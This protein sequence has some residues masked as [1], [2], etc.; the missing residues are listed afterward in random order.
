[1]KAGK[2]KIVHRA[3]IDHTRVA[4]LRA[5]LRLNAV[6]VECW[7]DGV[8]SSRLYASIG[9]RAEIK[10]ILIGK[11]IVESL[12]RRPFRV[13]IVDACLKLAGAWSGNAEGSNLSGELSAA[14]RVV[15]IGCNGDSLGGSRCSRIKIEDFCIKRH[16]SRIHCV[17]VCQNRV[18]ERR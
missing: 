4:K 5:P 3:S 18:R 15:D 14:E 10:M 12:R 16:S 2:R 8:G 7:I 6:R 17:E 9:P 1:V 11:V 13:E